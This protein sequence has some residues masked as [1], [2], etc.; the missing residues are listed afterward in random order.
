MEK[1]YYLFTKDDF[2]EDAF[3]RE[4]VRYATPE[5]TAF[6][7]AYRDGAPPNAA[8]MEQAVE[9]LQAICCLERITPATGDKAQV[10]AQI[11]AGITTATPVLPITRSYRK[12]WLAAAVLL[13]LLILTAWYFLQSSGVHRV[14]S[15]YGQQVRVKLPDSSVVILNAH[16][17]LTYH[18]WKDG[19]REVWL[20][21]EALFDVRHAEMPAA[22]HFTVHAGNVKI[23]VL[24]TVFN[25]KR[26][27][28]VTEVYL[29]KG[30]V[31]VSSPE[32][33][34]ILI[35]QPNEQATY[36]NQQQQLLKNTADANIA[37]AWRDHKMLLKQTTVGDIIH[38]LQ[39]TYGFTIILQDTSIANRT[40]EGTLSLDNV[41]NVLFELSAILNVKIEKN[42]DTLYLK[43]NGQRGY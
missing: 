5:A 13:P 7:E 8:A 43:D 6:W 30:K 37:L 39:D 21:G 25:V 19:R 22:Q 14:E 28:G 33:E 27:R 23:E 12:R 36:N 20:D 9:T 32:K 16:S 11:Q 4:W 35:L 10:W 3:F 41:N 34:Q 1:N 18:T 2:L 31:K 15:G 24:G 40:L 42:N 26:R 38:A 17:T 29:Q